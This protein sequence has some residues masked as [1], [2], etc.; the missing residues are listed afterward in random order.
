MNTEQIEAQR[1]IT[2]A[3]R[4]AM[5]EWYRADKG[6][7]E[8]DAA[9]FDAFYGDVASATASGARIAELEKALRPF[10]KL[11]TSCNS[12]LWHIRPDLCEAARAALAGS[13]TPSTPAA[14]EPFDDYPEFHQSAMGCGLEDRGITDRYDAMR[15]GWDEAIDRVAERV[16][17]YCAD[18]A[19]QDTLKN[20][21][22]E[23]STIRLE[24][25]YDALADCKQVLEGGCEHAAGA[26]ACCE[27]IKDSIAVESAARTATIESTSA[28]LKESGNV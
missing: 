21:D 1:V 17:Q 19:P 3:M 7:P 2:P 10:S 13:A 8:A 15:Y 26:A 6:A 4:K 16:S 25:L 12:D 5:R 28:T 22:S 24:A 9:L 18:L 23:K 20:A 14:I 27:A 11:D